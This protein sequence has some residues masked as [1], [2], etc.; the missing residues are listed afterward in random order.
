MLRVLRSAMQRK[1]RIRPLEAQIKALS[2]KIAAQLTQ[3]P[4]CP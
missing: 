3:F 2:E 4:N 1:A